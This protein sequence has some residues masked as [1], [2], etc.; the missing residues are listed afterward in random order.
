M[1]RPAHVLF[2]EDEEY[3]NDKMIRFLKANGLEVTLAGTLSEA[4]AAAQSGTYGCILLD[5]MIPPG[6]GQNSETEA[7][8]AGVEFLRRLR[9]GDLPGA[10]AQTPVIVLTGRPEAAVEEEMR[11]LGLDAFL[12][13]PESM[14]VVLSTIRKALA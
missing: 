8:T 14:K 9:G 2:I 7:L 1:G 11:A 6:E 10:D 4:L 5:V 12:N 13:K 3:R